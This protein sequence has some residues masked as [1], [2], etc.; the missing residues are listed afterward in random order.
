MIYYGA[1][2]HFDLWTYI[3]IFLVGLNGYIGNWLAFGVDRRL[4]KCEH[5]SHSQAQEVGRWV[6]CFDCGSL[7]KLELIA[8]EPM[9]VKV[10]DL[11]RWFAPRLWRGKEGK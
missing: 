3:L 9:G 7:A 4:K 11:G 8:T 5:Y 10:L 2:R 6:V 1:V